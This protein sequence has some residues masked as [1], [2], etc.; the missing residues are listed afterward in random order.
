[1]VVIKRS[2]MVM[3]VAVHNCDKESN[4]LGTSNPLVIFIYSAV[5]NLSR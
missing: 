1:M 2:C 5:D 3:V 4:C